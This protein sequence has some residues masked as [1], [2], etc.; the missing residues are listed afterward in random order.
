MSES[1]EER[2]YVRRRNQRYFDSLEDMPSETESLDSDDSLY[3]DYLTYPLYV[4]KYIRIANEDLKDGKNI[5]DEVHLL[6]DQFKITG[7]QSFSDIRGYI[8][9]R[10]TAANKK[11]EEPVSKI[12]IQKIANELLSNL[13]VSETTSDMQ[14]I[15]EEV[16]KKGY[17]LTQEEYE[18]IIK[19][20]IKARLDQPLF[21]KWV[22]WNK[23]K[24]R[25]QEAKDAKRRQDLYDNHKIYA[26]INI[27]LYQLRSGSVNKR[28]NYGL[29]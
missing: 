10:E 12:A 16:N 7:Y 22:N 28:I 20:F 5:Y 23:R 25:V 15:F 4:S 6:E 29:R 13:N 11:A 1:E 18:G 21:Q 3:L 17:M 27:P 14:K 26:G 8:L 19:P 9:T 2:R 24:H